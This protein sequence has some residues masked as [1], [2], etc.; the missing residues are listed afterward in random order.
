MGALTILV[1]GAVAMIGAAPAPATGDCTGEPAATYCLYRS[2]APSTG[3][4]VS[5]RNDRCRVGHYY[6]QPRDVVWFSPPPGME[7]FPRPEVI[8]LT[9]TLAQVRI[10][11]GHPCSVS[12]FFEV[13][14]H[15]LSDPRYAVLAVDT[16][17]L[18]IAA[19]DN[20]AIAI[21]QM[22]TGRE[23]LRLERDWAPAAWLGDVVSTLH[24][25]PDGRLSFTW[26][27]GTERAPVSERVSVPSIP[28]S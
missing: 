25:D 27:R 15:R 7:T 8:W 13:T 22:F 24:F 20:R 16:R 11:C 19:A 4:V 18:L 5:C 21:R 26:L 23:V 3:L 17:R 9:A 1:L 2:L 12:Y 6:G 10:D 14:R 28:R